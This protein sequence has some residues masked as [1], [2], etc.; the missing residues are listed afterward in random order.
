MKKRIYE[1][2]LHLS[3]AA[4][5]AALLAGCPAAMGLGEQGKGSVPATEIQDGTSGTEDNDDTESGKEP[6]PEEPGIQPLEDWED[7]V[8][9]LG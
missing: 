5:C 8:K 2:L 7:E 6:K 4:L 9:L 3:A 1:R